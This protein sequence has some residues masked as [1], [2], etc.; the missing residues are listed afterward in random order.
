MVCATLA[1]VRPLAGCCQGVM[2]PGW[3]D[4]CESRVDALV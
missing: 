2:V 4:V 3:G 1:D